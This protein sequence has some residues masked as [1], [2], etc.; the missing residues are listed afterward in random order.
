MGT[1]F[2]E[3]IF[4]I[5]LKFMEEPTSQPTKKNHKILKIVGFSL[6]GLFTAVSLGLFIFVWLQN[7]SLQSKIAD[8]DGEISKLTVQ[9]S[10]LTANQESA[11]RS[12][13]DSEKQ[14]LVLEDW[15]IKFK[16]PQTESEIVYYKEEA[17][18]VEY[19]DFTTRRVEALGGI[20]AESDDQGSVTRLG[21]ISRSSTK[22]E[23][24]PSAYAINDN[25]PLGDYYYYNSGAQ[26]LCADASPEIQAEDRKLVN[27]MLMNPILIK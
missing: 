3:T 10:E 16:L 26:S 11:S 6:L 9:V 12:T 8:K 18:G 17:N 7:Q 22:N 1:Y 21:S 19:Y 4:Y 13:N 23:D 2:P 15:G 14:Y 5:K 25:E 24:H 27:D 20:C